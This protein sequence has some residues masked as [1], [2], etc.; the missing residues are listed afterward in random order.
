MTMTTVCGSIDQIDAEAITGWAGNLYEPTKQLILRL[1]IDGTPVQEVVCDL[2]RPD[3]VRSRFPRNDVG[4]TA[5]L[6]NW[7]LDGVEHTL[8]F[9]DLDG[10][11]MDLIELEVL[12]S[13]PIWTNRGPWKHRFLI[14][15]RRTRLAVVKGRGL[16]TA[17]FRE[18]ARDALIVG[19]SESSNV[20]ASLPE[21]AELPHPPATE[22]PMAAV[23][24]NAQSA[25]PTII[26]ETNTFDPEWY[27]STYPDIKE[28]GVDPL[29]HYFNY[30]HLDRN[31]N[32]YFDTAYYREVCQ[33]IPSGMNTLVHY[34]MIGEAQGLWPCSYFNP[35]Y[36]RS[37][38]AIP[39]DQS[40]LGHY[41]LHRYEAKFSPVEEFDAEYYAR[42]NE[43]VVAAGVDIYEHYIGYGF[44]E[45]R[46]PSASFQSK[47]YKTRYLQNS[48]ECPLLH[49][50]RHRGEPGIYPSLPDHES[51]VAREVKRFSSAGLDFEERKPLPTTAIRRAKVL[52]YYLPQFHE[53]PENDEWWGKGFT[54]WT[55]VA[56]GSP[57]FKDHYQPR[58]PRDLGFYTLDAAVMRQQIQMAVE[59]GLFGF[60]FYFYWF[61]GRR[62]MERPLNMFLA[63]ASLQIPFCLMWA[64]ENWSR[65]WDGSENEVL[66]SQNYRKGDDNALIDAFVEAFRDPL[67]IRLG[68]RPLLMIYRPGIIPDCE[69]VVA[70]WRALFK[71]RSGEDPIIIMS[72]SFN[73]HDPAKYGLDG[74]IEFPPHKLV[75]G[76][77]TQNKQLSYLDV[78]ADAHVYSYDDVS[79]YS[80]NE[81]RPRFPLIKTVVPSWDNDARRQGAGLVIHGSNPKKYQ[82]WLE[83]L[84]VQSTENEF[85]G[86]R[87]VCVNAWNEW[88]EGAYLEPDLHF[89]SA[90][91]NATSRAVVGSLARGNVAKALLIGHDAFP[92]GAQHLLLNIG[93]TLKR[94]FGLDIEFLLLS[95]GKLEKSYAGCAP[96]R[97]IS[98]KK[99]A[100]D[101]ISEAKSRGFNSTLINTSAAAWICEDLKQNQ[102]STTLLIHE[103]PNL[104]TEKGLLDAARAGLTHA[105]H[106]VFASIFVEK[107]FQKACGVAGKSNRILPQGCY[108]KISFSPSSRET[109]R[110]KLKIGK[111]SILAI[112]IGYADL[113]K[114]FDIFLQMWRSAQRLNP[115]VHCC[116]VGGIDPVLN[117]YLGAE[118]THAVATGTFHM[119]GY[120]TDVEDL[121]SAADV[122]ILTSREDP[123]P[124][125]V[126]EAMSAGLPIVAFEGG[127]GIPDLVRAD[128]A[129]LIVGM[130]DALAAAEG[131]LKLANDKARSKNRVLR[132]EMASKNSE[133]AP[134]VLNLCDLMI[135][136]RIRISVVVPNYNYAHHLSARLSSIFN[137]TYPVHEIIVL[138]DCST[139]E[140]VDL[141]KVIAAE[142]R[143]DVRL[144]VNGK[145]SGSVF[146]QWRKA[147]EV[148][149]GDYIWI[150]EADDDSDPRFLERLAEKLINSSGTVL[151]FSDSRAIDASGVLMWKDHKGY[152][153]SAGAH[154]LS[155]DGTYSGQEFVQ[156]FLSERN[157]ILNVSSAVWHR[158]TFKAAI[159]RCA[160][161]LTN[162]RMA[163]D[164]HLYVDLLT[165]ADCNVSYVS[166]PLNVHRRHAASVTHSL[167]AQT[168]VDEIDSVHR[169]VLEKLKDK[170][171]VVRQATYVAN[172]SEQLGLVSQTRAGTH[173]VHRTVRRRKM[174]KT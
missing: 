39:I 94:S 126:L 154:A 163:G 53:F 161:G 115:L 42:N 151:A 8:E 136:D 17:L 112:G 145:N 48:E 40:C 113:R 63:D 130:G 45:G 7:C 23:H 73:D 75:G 141:I 18:A 144:I 169:L 97:V 153:A 25:G 58:V 27:T 172:V 88:A 30:G 59:A 26:S 109:M 50:I 43:D 114:G 147:S 157:L 138:D 170:T 95:G 98:E 122:F 171:P 108:N 162:Y 57:R 174:V 60:I 105:D 143:R 83:Q 150:A 85:F 29:L 74:A 139:D 70:A 6:P 56:R 104:L 142:W 37:T 137:Q 22:L 101:Y 5:R 2:A 167:D 149:T 107:E 65:R 106:T 71:E 129:G 134:Y 124:T 14:E 66:I 131:L 46:N 133:F 13:R 15:R 100:L 156:R 165:G 166:E 54:E 10:I 84:I 77:P 93:H 78:D 86:E 79:N 103:L 11:P 173:P 76:L 158:P 99:L 31:P 69:R 90:Y 19:L 9:H 87:L 62:L 119:L 68:G 132:A 140:S 3:I 116:W 72:Q 152:F 41:L 168:H 80:I 28:A 47:F 21:P 16:L 64:N 52:A 121:L 111:E 81:P 127:G 34:L 35:T 12:N 148:A 67:Y 20:E 44:Q 164:W 110:N 117:G 38:Y 160:D 135:P 120:R 49:Y 118:I 36:Y 146:K 1:L 32:S 51:S 61:D 92:S 96:T 24:V 89:G 155:A 4:F 102:F 82:H 123:F 55:N 125:V 159:C 91:L 33:D 128:D